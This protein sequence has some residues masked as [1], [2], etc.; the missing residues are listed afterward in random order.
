MPLR[1]RIAAA[2]GVA[3]ALAVVAVSIAVYVG[4]RGELRDEVDASL[5]D[6]ADAVAVSARS[7]GSARVPHVPPEPF[8]GPEGHVQLVLPNGRL[9]REPSE[10][11]ALPVDARAHAIA[12][13]G[14]GEELVD[15][16]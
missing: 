3:V 7:T 11:D 15:T 5:R 1:I 10:G 2:A 16:T 9:V 13:R 4:V 8:G 14:L 6:R 12:R